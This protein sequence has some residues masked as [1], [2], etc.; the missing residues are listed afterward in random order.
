LT[1]E[2][3]N[4]DSYDEMERVPE[5]TLNAQ[6]HSDEAVQQTPTA[7]PAQAPSQPAPIVETDDEILE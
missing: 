5:E 2:P 7:A 6:E 3:E 1:E 4:E